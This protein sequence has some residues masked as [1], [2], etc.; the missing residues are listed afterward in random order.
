MQYQLAV[1]DLDGTILDTLKDLYLAV[2]HALRENGLPERT[3]AEV[4]QF[5]GNGPHHLLQCS[6]P[7]GS[8]AETIAR[9][10]NS[11]HA[12]YAQHCTDY[13][14]PYPGIPELIAALRK[15]GLQTAVVSNKPDY[16]VQT[17]IADYFPGLFDCAVGERENVRRKPA[18]DAVNAVLEQLH[19]PRERAVYIG[20][21]EVDIATAEQAG[22][23]CISV[24]WGF[25]SVQFLTDCGA[26]QIVSSPAALQALLLG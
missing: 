12:Y 4:R 9:T 2:N 15:A 14:R 26:A 21:S 16:G 8:S 10:E 20:D 1:F 6:V 25:R 3:S 19:I 18:P 24:D 11:F 5:L 23:P 17:L 13:T 22:M 7:A